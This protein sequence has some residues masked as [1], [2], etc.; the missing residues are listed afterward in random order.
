MK[1]LTHAFYFHLVRYVEAVVLKDSNDSFMSYFTVT[2]IDCLQSMKKKMRII[3]M[4]NYLH[5]L[6]QDTSIIY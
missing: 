5:F 2:V 4:Q 1:P 6:M 3:Y